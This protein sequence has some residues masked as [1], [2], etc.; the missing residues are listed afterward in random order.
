MAKVFRFP[1]QLYRG[2]SEQELG[3]LFELSMLKKEGFDM[4]KLRTELN[5]VDNFL[6][7]VKECEV[8]WWIAGW[9]C[10]AIGFIMQFL[11]APSPYWKQAWRV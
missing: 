7:R 5:K 9:E 6:S 1:I 3:H 2:I 11:S 10:G 8:V 4:N